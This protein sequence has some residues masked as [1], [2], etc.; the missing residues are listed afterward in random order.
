[1]SSATAVCSSAAVAIWRFMSRIDSTEAVIWRSMAPALATCSAPASLR[2]CAFDGARGI[3]RAALHGIDDLVDLGDGLGGALRQGADL[4]GDHRE[5]TAGIAGAG[6]FDGRVE[7]E[8]V[9]L[10][11]NAADHV[12]DLADPAAIAFQLADDLHRMVDL[13]AHLA[14]A[15]NRFFHHVFAALGGI[16]RLVGGLAAS[17]A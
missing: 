2:D 12:E 16:V 8:Q 4:V 7:G 3:H 13:L 1:M 10:L 11:G 17:P 14:D 9:G 5:A 6:G 15:A